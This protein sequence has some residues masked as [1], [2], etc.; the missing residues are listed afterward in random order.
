MT[1]ES[2]DLSE[3]GCF[4]N[5]TDAAWGLRVYRQAV[6]PISVQTLGTR[7]RSLSW[8]SG[9]RS[10]SR[11]DRPGLQSQPCYLLA[12]DLATVFTPG[13][14]RCFPVQK[15]ETVR[16][17]KEDHWERGVESH[18]LPARAGGRAL[19]VLPRLP[20]TAVEPTTVVWASSTPCRGCRWC[21]HCIGAMTGT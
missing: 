19:P 6:R 9:V 2:V 15:V 12:G 7:A 14:P 17:V 4:V 8:C 21:R 11:P 3:D 5:V 18:S 20:W 13:A 10:S 1:T 16:V